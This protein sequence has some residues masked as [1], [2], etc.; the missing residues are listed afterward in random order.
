[1]I[2]LTA[3]LAPRAWRLALLA[4]AAGAWPA[5][6]D[7]GEPILGAMHQAVQPIVGDAPRGSDPAL[8]RQGRWLFLGQQAFAAGDATSS[9]GL[10][11][12]MLACGACHGAR[13]QGQREGGRLAPSLRFSILQQARDGLPA[14]ADEAAL[15]RAVVQGI[16]RGGQ[17]LD[18]AMPRFTRL[19]DGEWA[20][21]LAHLRQAGT[22]ADQPTGVGQGEVLLGTVLPLSGPGAAAGQPV[23]A[24]LHAVL[25]QVNAMGGVHGRQLRLVA[26]DGAADGAR[27]AGAASTANDPNPS[28]SINATAL[29]ARP[30]L[31]PPEP[32]KPRRDPSPA[33]ARVHAALQSLWAQPVYALVGG[34]WDE[35]QAQVEPWLAAAQWPHIGAL[36]RRSQP[37]GVLGWS[38]DLLPP[39]VQQRL[40]QQQALAACEGGQGLAVHDD[41]NASRQHAAALPTSA[42]GQA[43]GHPPIQWVSPGMLPAAIRE[44]AAP[45]CV[46]YLLSEAG[47]ARALVPAGWR[48]AVVLPMPRAL[49]MPREGGDRTSLWQRLGEQA[50]WLA[51]ELLGR[52]GR[53]LHERA[54]LDQLQGLDEPAARSARLPMQFQRQQ[55]HAWSPEVI[56]WNTN[57]ATAAAQGN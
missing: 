38:A 55:S 37:V 44:A 30:E 3:S 51:V 13:A 57:A 7:A 32:G 34:V 49:A 45:G 2:G 16:G 40:A 53:G 29:R 22:A 50:A 15:R 31:Q 18:A 26:V 11:A 1:M 27:E 42:S 54:L 43:P 25:A 12:A 4:A 28:V 24:G 47:P 9:Q 14:Y 6:S 19:T 8:A 21:L 10:P 23:L 33:A 36:V 48:H 5:L 56:R 17:A 41:A 39:L 52:A 20:A 35:D 46:A